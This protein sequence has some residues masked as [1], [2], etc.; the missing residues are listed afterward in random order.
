VRSTKVS[1]TI[2]LLATVDARAHFHRARARHGHLEGGA[3]T[4]RPL[5]KWSVL[6]SDRDGPLIEWLHRPPTGGDRAPRCDQVC[7]TALH[8]YGLLGCAVLIQDR[9]NPRPDVPGQANALER[10]Q[11]C[12]RGQDQQGHGAS[13]FLRS[14]QCSASLTQLQVVQRPSL[15]REGARH[16]WPVPLSV[17]PSRRPSGA[18]ASPHSTRLAHL[19]C[20]ASCRSIQL[21]LVPGQQWRRGQQS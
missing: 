16:H 5:P 18:S 1:T 12:R 19:A 9:C 21:A 17:R 13:A 11:L 7:V 3:W 8:F 20:Q 4:A 10:T 15:R 2:R 14:R 6:R